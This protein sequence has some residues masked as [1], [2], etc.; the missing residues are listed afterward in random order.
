MNNPIALA[1]GLICLAVLAHILGG[2]RESLA[3][4]PKKMSGEQAKNMSF[5][6]IERNWVQLM[7]AFQLVSIDLIAVAVVLYLLAFTSYLQPAS[8]IAFGMAVF[9]AAWGIV[10]LVQLASLKRAKRD[11]A[12]LGQW[13][14]WFVC[15]G[16]LTWGARTL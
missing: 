12:L 8:Q 1:F 11:Y 9:F 16:L 13:V 10:W 15:S 7:C 14:L 5:G 3:V 6:R 2:I 4:R